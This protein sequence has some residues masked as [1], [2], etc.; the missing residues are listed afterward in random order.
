MK[1]KEWDENKGGK[2]PSKSTSRPIRQ[3]IM[4]TSGRKKIKIKNQG[5]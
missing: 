3:M 2:C 1:I 5:P 4:M